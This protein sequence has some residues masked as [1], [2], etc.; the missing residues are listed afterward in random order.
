MGTEYAL[1]KDGVVLEVIVCDAENI[2]GRDGTWVLT[3]YNPE[4]GEGKVG[5]G[6]LYDG[7]TFAPPKTQGEKS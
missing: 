2:V 5:K 7:K 3:P 1:V 6:F 4:T